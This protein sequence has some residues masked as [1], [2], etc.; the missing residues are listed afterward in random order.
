MTTHPDY[1]CRVYYKGV[2]VAESQREYCELYLSCHA[3]TMYA[4]YKEGWTFEEIF[5]QY[6]S[7]EG[8]ARLAICMATHVA[9]RAGVQVNASV[10]RGHEDAVDAGT[11]V[12]YKGSSKQAL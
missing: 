10:R 11:G 8:A 6:P 12:T 3:T 9:S 1:G 5:E 4:R 7:A 2:L